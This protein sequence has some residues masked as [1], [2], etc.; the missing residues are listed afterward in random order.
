MTRIALAAA[1]LAAFVLPALAQ[2]LP[3]PKTGQ[4]PSGYRESGGYCAPTSDRAPPAIPKQGQCAS[5][6]VQS[7]NYCIEARRR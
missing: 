2:P 6:W 3:L 4:C 5:N 7:G 1:I